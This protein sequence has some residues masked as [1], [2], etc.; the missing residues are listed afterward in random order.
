[1][2]QGTITSALDALLTQTT[3]RHGGVPG[4]VA[5]AHRPRQQVYEGAAGALQAL[6]DAPSLI[7]SVLLRRRTIHAFIVAPG[8]FLIREEYL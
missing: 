5:M 3:Q 2:P 1:M 7:D 4:V 8:I 6:C